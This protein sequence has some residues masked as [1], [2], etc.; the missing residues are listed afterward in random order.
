MARMK[1]SWPKFCVNPQMSV[2]MPHNP[3]PKMMTPQLLNG[4]KED[5]NRLCFALIDEIAKGQ[6]KQ[7]FPAGGFWFGLRRCGHA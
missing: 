5:G 4:G 3:V 1:S 7:R 2:Q 6:G